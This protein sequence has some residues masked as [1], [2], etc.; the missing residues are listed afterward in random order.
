MT[1]TPEQKQTV[2]TWVE[3]GDNLSTVQ[4][5]LSEQFKI[6]MTYMDVRFLVDDLGLELKNAAPKVD[7]TDVSKSAPANPAGGGA[8]SPRAA[9]APPAKK[10]FLDKLKEK[11]G[12][13]G[14]DDE[15]ELPADDMANAADTMPAPPVGGVTVDL[16]RIVRPG[17]VVS[18]TVTFSD[19][20]SGKWALDQAGRLML[21]TG[22]P[23]YKPAPMD[24]QDFQRELSALLQRHGM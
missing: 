3:A 9:S 21:D 14:G 10:G 7:T 1:L 20:V 13:G 24:V 22:N 12:V 6:S 2:A 23:G 18:G 16:D 15:D 19:G 11:V 17:A 8:P 4:R 5:K